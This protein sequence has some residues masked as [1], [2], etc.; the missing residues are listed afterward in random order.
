[1]GWKSEETH[2]NCRTKQV[3][4]LC[5]H[6]V[7]ENAQG[8]WQ[9]YLDSFLFLYSQGWLSTAG[10]NIPT[11]YAF[12]HDV[13]GKWTPPI[14]LLDSPL[15]SPLHLLLTVKNSASFHVLGSDYYCSSRLIFGIHS[16]F[17]TNSNMKTLSCKPKLIQGQRAKS[18]IR[19]PLTDLRSREVII[20]PRF[21]DLTPLFSRTLQAMTKSKKQNKGTTNRFTQQRGNNKAKIPRPHPS[22]LTLPS[23]ISS[24]LIISPL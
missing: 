16:L 2:I 9:L 20:R 7:F 8:V 1:M 10:R 4:S 14:Q 5:A 6:G 23:H 12:N 11:V 24:K 18:K 3:D 22:L 17:N 19:V 15:S 13:V 21:Q